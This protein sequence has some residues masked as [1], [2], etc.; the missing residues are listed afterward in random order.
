ME[1]IKINLNPKTNIFI[2]LYVIFLYK[3][4]YFIIYNY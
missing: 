2:F 3:F 4:I 1:Q